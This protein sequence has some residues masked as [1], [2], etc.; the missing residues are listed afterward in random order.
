MRSLRSMNKHIVSLFIVLAITLGFP[1]AA[2][3]AMPSFSGDQAIYL[4]DEK[5]GTVL[6]DQNGEEK[7]YPASTTKMLTTLVALDYVADKMD[8]KVTVGDEVNMVS[9]DSSLAEIKQG[10]SL[11]WKELFYGML[12]PSGNDAA[13]TISVNVARMATGNNNLSNE[14]AVKRFVEMMNEKAD[15]MGCETY[16]F[17]NP[18]G[19][20]DDNHYMTAKDMYIISH[21]VLKN[22]DIA[23]IVKSPTYSHQTTT[24][25]ARPWRNTNFLVVDN[26][27]AA[28]YPDVYEN[29]QNPL[30]NKEATGVKTGFTDQAGRCLVFSANTDGKNLLGIIYKAADND[31]LYGQANEV[32]ES[33]K[34]D[35]KQVTWT[36]E[37][38]QMP[39]VKVKGNHFF[40]GNSLKLSTGNAAS[41]TV[42]KD[43]ESQYSTSITLNDT[44]LEKVDDETYKVHADIKEGDEIGKLDV[45]FNG[46]DYQSFP[47]YA[48]NKMRQ[49]NIVDF[50]FWA[51]IVILIIAFIVLARLYF[52]SR[53]NKTGKGA[54]HSGKRKKRL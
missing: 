30:Y 6:V 44:T 39:A 23:Q 31:V 21:E 8:T 25:N 28:L 49:R 20:H 11:T 48:G 18:H 7:F 32:I 54:A 46:K 24:P 34:N 37:Y 42:L 36:D 14:E 2:F 50:L 3:A 51:L 47:I 19:L 1:G 38:N 29:G 27:S 45:K 12:L 4:V 16:N 35:Y 5:T 9:T 40:D 22:S 43:K 10:E 13:I 15:E 41:S 52:V 33:L 26:G 17:V 53:K